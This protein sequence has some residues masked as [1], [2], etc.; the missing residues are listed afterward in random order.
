[1]SSLTAELPTE[2]LATVPTPEI[3]ATKPVAGMPGPLTGAQYALDAPYAKLKRGVKTG[4]FGRTTLAASTALAQAIPNATPHG[5][6]PHPAPGTR[7]V[8]RFVE[9]GVQI[10]IDE[11]RYEITLRREAAATVLVVG[12]LAA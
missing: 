3:T 1:M 9:G 7:T 5:D 11:H 12:R 2:T 6:G 4:R 8:A 10:L